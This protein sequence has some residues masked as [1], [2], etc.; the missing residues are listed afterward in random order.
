MT[1]LVTQS[2]EA[3]SQV[4]PLGGLVLETT[5]R[6][7]QQIYTSSPMWMVL[8][9][10]TRK[11]CSKGSLGQFDPTDSACSGGGISTTVSRDWHWAPVMSCEVCLTQALTEENGLLRGFFFLFCFFLFFCFFVFA[12]TP[13]V[14]GQ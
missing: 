9:G 14:S 13:P 10:G 12:C 4:M 11:A 3:L 5:L 7:L 1:F 8:L 6:M 2:R